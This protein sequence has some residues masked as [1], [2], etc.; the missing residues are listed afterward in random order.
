MLQLSYKVGRFKKE[1]ENNMTKTERLKMAYEEIKEGKIIEF[2]SDEG[3]MYKCRVWI[4]DCNKSNRKYIAYRS[5]GQ[6]A[7]RMGLD[8]LRWIAKT[9]GKC[10]TYNYRIVGSIY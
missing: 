1:G 10:T 6:S 8:N 4:K 3:E 2:Q 5:F 7:M 9:I